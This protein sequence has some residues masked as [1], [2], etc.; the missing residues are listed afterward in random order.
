MIPSNSTTSA[1]GD[2]VISSRHLWATTAGYGA[3]ALV[4]MFALDFGSKS[5]RDRRLHKFGSPPPIVPYKAP[6][7]LDLALYSLFRFFRY[8]F[9]ELV[10]GW[11]DAAPGRTVELR[12]FG[13]GLIF[14]DA[15]ENI[16]DIMSTR[17]TSFG[18]GEV[19]RRIWGDM[20]GDSQIFV[21]DGELWHQSK[22][23]IK[24]HVGKLRADD[25]EITE[26]HARQLFNRFSTDVPVEV[27]DLV[28]RYQLDVVTD[29]FFGES[30]ESLT[31]EPPFRGPMDTLHP[32]NTARMLFGKLAYYVKDKYIAPEA[33]RQLDAYT[34]GVADRAF[35]RDLSQKSPKD[36]NMLED[37]VSQKKTYKDLKDSMMS[38]ML[39]GKDPSAILITWAIFLMAKNP[40][41][42]KKMQ[43]QVAIVCGDNLPTA[44]DLKDLT[45]IRYVINETFR[46]YHPLGL[47]VRMALENTTLSTGGGKAGKEPVAV[48]KDT[49][50]IYSL[51]GMQRRKDIWGDDALEW[52]PDR[53]EGADVDRWHFIP[54]NH[55][56]RHC[57]GRFFGQQQMEY[58][59][60]RICQEYEAIQ[61]PDGQP[62][63]QIRVELN[64]K[65]AHPCMCRFV[66]KK[67]V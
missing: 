20:L 30:A 42:M 4:F 55:G 37:L 64:L 33:L 47:N 53:W 15:P 16:K 66:T 61:V 14:T 1:F 26:K 67:G 40:E 43:A 57:L 3:L 44:S 56:P 31:S 23:R 54:Y 13:T 5:Y 12:M 65:M 48:P 8:T 41:V 32:I 9:F 63:Q 11:L 17:W 10:C 35:A 58:I 24:S 27:Y 50:I 28:D 25:L 2:V 38:I 6:L 22:E 19:T 62:E 7:G 52:R 45:Y 29:V 36:Y 49:T 59:L 34:T 60:A 21:V 46:L 18:R 39:G 51:G